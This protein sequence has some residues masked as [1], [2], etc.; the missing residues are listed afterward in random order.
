MNRKDRLKKLAG[1]QEQLKALHE[2]RHAGF[3]AH[4]AAAQ[5]EAEALRE[6]FDAEGSMSALFPEVYHRRIE[7]A[8]ERAARNLTLADQEAGL[9]ATATARTNMV[10]RAWRSATRADDRTRSDRERLE[11]IARTRPKEPKG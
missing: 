2:M 6:R 9:V 10:E 5:A 11:M 1:V 7:R 8:L 3:R 4:A